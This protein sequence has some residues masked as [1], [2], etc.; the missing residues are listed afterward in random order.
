MHANRASL[1]SL[2]LYFQPRSTPFVWL[3]ARTWIRKNTDCFAVYSVSIKLNV[4]YHSPICSLT[5]EFHQWCNQRPTQ[6]QTGCKLN[7]VR[8]FCFG[9]S[10]G[11]LGEPT[12]KSPALGPIVSRVLWLLA[13]LSLDT[14]EPQAEHQPVHLQETAL[15]ATF[16]RRRMSFRPALKFSETLCSQGTVE[17]FRSVHTEILTAR[18]LNFVRLAWFCVNEGIFNRS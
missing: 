8:S 2:A 13:W 10:Y 3:L 15:N 9:L 7:G 18:C 5:P 14:G 6:G 11:W 1:P 17:Y 16:T 4:S 12:R